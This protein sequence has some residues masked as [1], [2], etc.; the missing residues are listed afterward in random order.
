[1]RELELFVALAEQRNFQRA[2]SLC[3]LSASAASRAIRRLEQQ[4]GG[5]L[6]L[7]DNRSVE[8]TPAGSLLLGYARDALSRWHQ[9]QQ[10]LKRQAEVPR[11]ELRLFCSVTAVY[12]VL[13]DLLP[14]WREQ[15]PEIELHVHTG[16]QAEAIPRVLAGREDLAIA[17]I[18]D[19]L[20]PKLAH[21]TLQV[22]P[23]RFIAPVMDCQVRRDLARGA[24][25]S[26]LPLIVPEH[27]LARE[28]LDNWFAREGS[29]ARIYAQ[30]SGHE[31]VVSL[32][33]LG[34]GVGLVPELV[35][36]NSPLRQEIAVVSDAPRL[37]PFD[38]S[39]V[40][41]KRRLRDPLVVSLWQLAAAGNGQ[42]K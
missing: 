7:R 21:L 5:E 25:W 30:V 40:C 26:E 13:V 3:N 42:T 9:V 29:R 33:A 24:G 17:A 15:Y 35:I 22:S 28:R 10:Q 34:F 11:G 37:E 36:T 19:V 41:L 8:L 1:M 38:I 12:S 27:G 6:F 14:G 4:V 31:A 16:D 23:L 32:V 18:P 2:A 20:P 39:L